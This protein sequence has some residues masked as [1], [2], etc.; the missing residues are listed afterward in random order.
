MANKIAQLIDK[1]LPHSLNVQLLTYDFK[2]LQV[3]G[4]EFSMFEKYNVLFIVG[5]QDPKIEK[6]P[7]LS[8]EGL[9]EKQDEKVIYELFQGKMNSEQVY[10]F[11]KSIIKNFSLENLMSHLNIIDP[12][13]IIVSVEHIIDKLQMTH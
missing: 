4:N 12:R 11:K 5:N 3:E 6:I 7:F 1:S 10:S 9:I 8:I 2:N 13:K